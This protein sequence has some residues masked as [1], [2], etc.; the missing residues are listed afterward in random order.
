MNKFTS[1]QDNKAILKNGKKLQYKNLLWF[2]NIILIHTLLIF[3]IL[4]LSRTG[5]NL[6][7]ENGGKLYIIMI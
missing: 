5:V 2:Q 4:L 7:K 1:N 6:E 3:I